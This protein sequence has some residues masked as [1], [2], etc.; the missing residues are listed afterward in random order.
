M[1][2]IPSM[3]G[4]ACSVGVRTS[5]KSLWSRT[6]SVYS[7]K[8]LSLDQL[9]APITHRIYSLRRS[10]SGGGEFRTGLASVMLKKYQYYTAMV[11][12]SNDPIP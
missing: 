10:I 5:F 3:Y 6:N 9:I 1:E 4:D 12:F 11:S 2:E 7:Y 8:Q